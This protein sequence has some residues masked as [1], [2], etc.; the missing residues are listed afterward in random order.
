M[1]KLYRALVEFSGIADAAS[2]KKLKASRKTD[3]PAEK[4]ALQGEVHRQLHTPKDKPFP[5]PSEE[6]AKQWLDAGL[7]E[8]V[9]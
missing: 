8:E 2:L 9:S 4:L 6:V 3:D 5:A 1:A 7:I